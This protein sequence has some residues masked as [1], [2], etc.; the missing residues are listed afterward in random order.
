MSE[1]KNFLLGSFKEHNT[2]LCM[3]VKILQ[4]G[5]ADVN[6]LVNANFEG[7]LSICNYGYFWNSLFGSINFHFLI[8]LFK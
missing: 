3:P 6:I 5:S 2:H 8:A 1:N 4:K 7:N